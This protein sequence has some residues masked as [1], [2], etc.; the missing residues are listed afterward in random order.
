MTL[1]AAESIWSVVIVALMSKAVM[2]C[3]ARF[4][5]SEVLSLPS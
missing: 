2:V 1:A 4:D 3:V 5:Y